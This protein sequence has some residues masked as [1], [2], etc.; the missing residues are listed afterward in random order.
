[1]SP[2]T[3]PHRSTLAAARQRMTALRFSSGNHGSNGA[4]GPQPAVLDLARRGLIAGPI[5]VAGCGE[6]EDALAL[7]PWGKVVGVDLSASA[8]LAARRKAQ[9]RGVPAYFLQR[10]VTH[11]MGLR[12]RFQTVVDAGLFHGLDGPRRIR[13]A[14]QLARLVEPGGHVHVLCFSQGNGP[15][16]DNLGVRRTELPL[17]LGAQFRLTTVRPEHFVVPHGTRDA[18]LAT[19]ER[20]PKQRRMRTPHV[21]TPFIHG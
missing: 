17:A 6:G 10:D 3:M 1:M 15:R 14:Q 19:Y 20:I 21:A 9:K 13:Y 12:Y 7:A 8:I 18:W 11:S 4:F 5:L 16:V 2:A